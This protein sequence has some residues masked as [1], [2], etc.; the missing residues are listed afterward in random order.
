[1]A[2]QRRYDLVLMDV[3]MPH[4]DGLEATRALRQL[5]GWQAVPVLAM[6]ANVFDDDRR[7]CEEA[8]MNDF[9]AKPVEAG[10][11]YAAL[12]RWLPNQLQKDAPAVGG[13]APAPAA[14]PLARAA[15]DRLRGVPGMDVDHGLA[16]MLGRTERYLAILD[17]FLGSQPAQLRQLARSLANGEPETARRIAHT[18]K[19]AA[20]TMG[21]RELAG[22]AAD[23]ES[24]LRRNPEATAKRKAGTWTVCSAASKP[25]RLHCA[26]GRP[27]PSP[28]AP[29]P[30]P[31]RPGLPWTSWPACCPVPT[32]PPSRCTNSTR[33][34]CAICWVKG[35]RSWASRS[36]PSNSRR[37]GRA[38]R[39]C[40]RRAPIGV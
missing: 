21:A 27:R 2:R 35:P 29:S 38:C 5:P 32:P 1:M 36:W 37:P 23:I 18:L 3:Q 31:K 34:G 7:A 30:T 39:T 8:G 22:L 16:L 6:T 13:A 11:L 17:R 10:L 4:M 19:G 9:I 25:S 24:G 33:W 12:L 28:S 14:S 20:A 15:V 26:P 40:V